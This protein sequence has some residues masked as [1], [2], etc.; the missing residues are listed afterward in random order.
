M[1]NLFLLRSYK[2]RTLDVGMYLLRLRETDGKRPRAEIRRI[3]E[4]LSFFFFLID[5]MVVPQG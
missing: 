4:I 5:A 3:L 2:V 1:E